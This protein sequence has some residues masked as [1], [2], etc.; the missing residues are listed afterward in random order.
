MS[1]PKHIKQTLTDLKG[2]INKNA[3]RVGDFNT[4]LSTL[5]RTSREKINEETANLNND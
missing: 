3:K 5:E 4:T 1:T 2:E